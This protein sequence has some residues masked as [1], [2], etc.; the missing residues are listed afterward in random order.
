[1]LLISN[2]KLSIATSN[3][4][5]HIGNRATIY[6]G[7]IPRHDPDWNIILTWNPLDQV[8]S[9]TR[10]LSNH[11]DALYIESKGVF[12]PKKGIGGCPRNQDEAVGEVDEKQLSFDVRLGTPF[13]SPWEN[14]P[15]E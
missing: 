3:K 12:G 11:R 14:T 10:G 13:S 6:L 5:L 1:M 9:G 4:K 7:T 2:K 8:R 15:C